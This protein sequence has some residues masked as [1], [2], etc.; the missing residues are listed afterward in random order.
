MIEERWQHIARWL[1]EHAPVAAQ[2]LRPG[3]ASVP[4]ELAL[5]QDWFEVQGGVGL[6]PEADI[7]MAYLPLS[8]DEAL[9]H[10]RTIASLIAD[11]DDDWDL[12]Y[13]G[14]ASLVPVAWHGTGPLL[15][16]DGR[17]GP[18]RGSVKELDWEDPSTLDRALWPDL[19]SML[20]DLAIALEQGSEVEVVGCRPE[21]VDGRLAWVWPAGDGSVDGEE[22]EPDWA[23]Q[24]G[25]WEAVVLQVVDAWMVGDDERCLALI[26]AELERQIDLAPEEVE[27][28]DGPGPPFIGTT[29][30]DA[31]IGACAE[32][33]ARSHG[34]EPPAWA[35]GSWRSLIGRNPVIDFPSGHLRRLGT[36]PGSFV[37]HGFVLE[38]TD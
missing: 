26:A 30:L 32:H 3:T 16:V 5:A 17:P 27:P 13:D 24:G 8:A 25:P 28:D 35:V 37:R 19:S 33:A 15:V 6:H 38:W 10:A 34:N 31:L 2:H 11:W 7:L 12:R 20:E 36:T 4:D 23:G 1:A 21:V 18:E 14:P 22:T 29:D 9:E